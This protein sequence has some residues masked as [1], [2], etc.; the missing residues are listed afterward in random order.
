MAYGDLITY[1]DI[2]LGDEVGPVLKNITDEDVA[3][4]CANAWGQTGPTRFT[5]MEIALQNKLKA[6]IVPGVMSVGLMTQLITG[7]SPNAVLKNLDVVFRQPVPHVEVTLSA[8]VTDKR[9]ED[10][11]N[12]LE[13][14][15]YLSNEESG[16]L[17][18]GKAIVTLPSKGS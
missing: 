11:D 16:R 5:N 8:L 7:W 4:F 18:I 9:E 6:P 17:I 3:L 15:V 14:D 12:I 2:D 1:E 10:G 13:C